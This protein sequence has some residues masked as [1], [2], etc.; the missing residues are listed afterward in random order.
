MDKVVKLVTKAK[1]QIR[2]HTYN[3]GGK[4]ADVKKDRISLKRMA[5][6]IRSNGTYYVNSSAFDHGRKN[7]GVLI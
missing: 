7:K 2:L 6:T 1:E 3:A 5:W 4:K